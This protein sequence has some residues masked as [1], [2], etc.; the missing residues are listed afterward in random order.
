M[1]V[2]FLNSK[3]T[4]DVWT[5]WDLSTSHDII[6]GGYGKKIEKV[7]HNMSCM[8][9]TNQSILE[10]ESYHWEGFGKIWSQRDDQIGV[11]LQNFLDRQ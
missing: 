9:F 1:V 5:S 7:S 2:W 11:L 6:R 10:E 3:K 8:M 4:N